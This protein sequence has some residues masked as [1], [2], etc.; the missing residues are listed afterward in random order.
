MKTLYFH[1]TGPMVRYGE[2][3]LYIEDLNPQAR[4]QWRMSRSEMFR[5]AWRAFIAAIREGTK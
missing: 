1:K 4:T 5:F 2:G 3:V